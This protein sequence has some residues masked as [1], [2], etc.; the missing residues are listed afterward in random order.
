MSPKP[1]ELFG[2]QLVAEVGEVDPVP[3]EEALLVMRQQRGV[4]IQDGDALD[5]ADA[6]HGRVPIAKPGEALLAARLF[7]IG[8]LHQNRADPAFAVEAHHAREFRK[9]GL[10]VPIVVRQIDHDQ[11]GRPS[12]P[13]T[14]PEFANLVRLECGNPRIDHLLPCSRFAQFLAARWAQVFSARVAP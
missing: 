6:S 14:F 9:E 7:R 5:L 10:G 3:P 4:E 13:G 2:H 11:L 12:R 1:I 8:L